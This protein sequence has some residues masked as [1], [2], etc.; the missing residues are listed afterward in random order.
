MRGFS[1]SRY[2]NLLLK[3]MGWLKL[4][5]S[6][7]PLLV[8]WETVRSCPVVR[9]THRASPLLVDRIRRKNVFTGIEGHA[10][11]ALKVRRTATGLVHS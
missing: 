7:P 10:R 6:E 11:P 5:V 9:G 1:R 3:K 4:E 8:G 2:Q